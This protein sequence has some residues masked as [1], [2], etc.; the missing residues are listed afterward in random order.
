MS[1]IVFFREDV[2]RVLAST[3]EAQRASA[4]AVAPLDPAHADAYQQGFE[5]ALRGVAMAFGVFV[6][7]GNGRYKRLPTV[8]VYPDDW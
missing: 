4:A 6:P 7:S 2:I 5:D 8:T 1:S 3:R